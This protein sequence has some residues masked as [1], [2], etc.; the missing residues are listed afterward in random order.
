MSSGSSQRST[1][2]WMAGVPRRKAVLDKRRCHVRRL[3]LPNFLPPSTHSGE[4]FISGHLGWAC[5]FLLPFPQRS[6][7][8]RCPAAPRPDVT[9][10]SKVPDLRATRSAFLANV[11]KSH[12]RQ[13]AQS[14]AFA[15]SLSS[16]PD[17]PSSHTMSYPLETARHHRPPPIS[18]HTTDAPQDLATS[19]FS[20]LSMSPTRSPTSPS[21][22]GRPRGGKR[23][24]SPP[25]SQSPVPSKALQSDLETFAEQ[26]RLWFVFN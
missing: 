14:A 11:C 18:I 12:P 7:P 19:P 23:I 6:V 16:Q 25:P 20:V 26:C 9:T 17:F 8:Q 3:T 2:H 15:H 21:F 22:N 1:V 13:P 10:D 24:K 5:A 4:A